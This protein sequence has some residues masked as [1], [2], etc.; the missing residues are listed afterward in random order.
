M[1]NLTGKRAII[2]RRVST[3]EQKDTGSSLA[4]Q[5]EHLTN[6]CARNDIE[7]MKDYE[8]DFSAKNFNRP[9][10][11]KLLEYAAKNKNNIDLVLFNKWDR[12]SRNALLGMTIVQQLRGMG[13]DVNSS[14][15][16]IDHDDPSQQLLYMIHMGIPEIDNRIRSGRTIT[17]TRR[18]L[19]DG[20]W[21]HSQPKGYISGRDELGKV[22]MQ[23]DPIL[24]PL[25]TELFN[26][27]SLGIY[28]Q[29][30]II[31][32]P[33][34]KPL[35]LSKSNLSR[36]LNQI[37]YSGRI[38]VKAFKHEPEQIVNSI[39]KPLISVEVF[40]KVQYELG[41]RKRI[42]HKPVKQNNILPLRGYIECKQCGG[43]LTGSGS[44]SKTG[45][46]HYYYHC[47]PRKGCN[48]RYKVGLAHEEISNLFNKIKPKEEVCEL[49]EHIMKDKFDNSESTNKS[50]IS[51]ID[52][53]IKKLRDRK[54]VLLDK[55]LD[56]VFENEIYKT[57]EDELSREIKKLQYEKSQINTYEKDSME[58]IKFG[59]HV[60]KNIGNFFEKATVN[61]KQKLISSIFKEKLV[62][63]NEKYRTPILNKGIELISQ[64]INVLEGFKNKNRRL[65]FDNLPLCTRDGT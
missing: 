2:Y 51:S 16:W 45:K 1:N 50:I 21:V 25:I 43:N 7:I 36:I 27:F 61:T 19:K 9:E 15:E 37:V 28:S 17:G 24:S 10:F 13:I 62:F 46:K 60:I 18:N 23:P 48:E 22:L 54:K 6:F 4:S 53:K 8:E 14:E 32:L 38:R 59:I 64:S 55:F 31:K 56:G 44:K 57:K 42:K 47:N 58:Y 30:Q 11:G 3:T 40:E 49:F 26:D 41:N 33:K 52:N 12:F 35:K 63:D 34:F 20:R 65:S 39:H 29:N 5:K